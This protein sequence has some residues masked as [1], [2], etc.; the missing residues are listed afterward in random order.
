MLLLKWTE[1]FL[2]CTNLIFLLK[3]LCFCHTDIFTAEKLN[4]EHMK[5]AQFKVICLVK[6]FYLCQIKYE[7]K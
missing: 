7:A 6:D 2:N 4:S 3:F 5:H 1:P